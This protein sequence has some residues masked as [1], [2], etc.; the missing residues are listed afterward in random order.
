MSPPSVDHSLDEFLRDF[1][2]ESRDHLGQAESNLLHLN[3][4]PDDEAAIHACFRSLHTIKGGAGFLG[5]TRIQALAHAAEHL[6]DRMRT[7][8]VS[9]GAE[10]VEALLAVISRLELILN[11]VENNSS[12]AA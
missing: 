12:G 11:Q 9:C 1:I 6:L 3:N 5:Q 4:H 8:G 7:G 10:H 2:S